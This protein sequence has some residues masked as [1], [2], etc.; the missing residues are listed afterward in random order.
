M[1]VHMQVHMQSQMKVQLLFDWGDR[2]IVNREELIKWIDR[3]IENGVARGWVP[4]ICAG[5][6]NVWKCKILGKTYYFRTWSRPKS[7][8]TPQMQISMQ[9]QVQIRMQTQF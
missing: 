2:R 1:Q 3:L 9:T 4:L 5:L 6:R 8:P 7:D